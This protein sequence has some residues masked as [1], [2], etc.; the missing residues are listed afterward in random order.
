MNIERT[1]IF[2]SSNR[3]KCVQGNERM[4]RELLAYVQVF[5]WYRLAGRVG[6]SRNMRTRLLGGRLLQCVVT[7][8][9]FSILRNDLKQ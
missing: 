1:K 8:T 3:L 7:A 2:R 4:Y 5:D 6:R 9:I